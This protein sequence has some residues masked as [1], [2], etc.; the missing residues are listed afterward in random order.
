VPE[1]VGR[2]GFRP[3][4]GGEL[5]GQHRVARPAG[6]ESGDDLGQG[7]A[8]HDRVV[9]AGDEALLAR[10]PGE[11]QVGDVAAERDVHR[12]AAQC[13]PALRARRAD[14]LGQ[15]RVHHPEQ[16]HTDP[17]GGEGGSHGDRHLR[18]V[19]APR[20]QVGADLVRVRGGD[21]LHAGGVP[22]RGGVLG[23]PDEGDRE[24]D[25][26]HGPDPQRRVARVLSR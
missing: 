12:G 2:G 6:R 3:C 10:E 22:A 16:L 7:C 15:L 21:E 5:L 9:A 23:E 25:V 26:R 11:D 14:H 1:P 4:D 18:D 8:V 19:H 17:S 20:R 13:I 24:R